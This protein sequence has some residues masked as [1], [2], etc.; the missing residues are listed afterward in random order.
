M[1]GG[2]RTSI[3]SPLAGLGTMRD[4]RSYRHSG[5]AHSTRNF[6]S[7][8]LLQSTADPTKLMHTLYSCT[9]RTRHENHCYVH[10]FRAHI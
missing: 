7:Y 8:S 4:A 1:M 9:A 6:S 3:H 5:S 2:R 10:L